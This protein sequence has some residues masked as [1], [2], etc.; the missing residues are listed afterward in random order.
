MD[1]RLLTFYEQELRFIR[2]MGAEFA[3][4]YPKIAGRLGMEGL[5]CADPYVERLLEGF[6]FLT[7][8]VQQKMDARF[9]EFTQQLLDLVYPHL[10]AP[11]PSMAVVGFQPDLSAGA[12]GSGYRLPPGTVL[13]S[14]LGKGERTACEYRTAHEVTL[15]P[16]RLASARYLANPGVMA[17]RGLPTPDGA[18]AAIQIDLELTSGER[19]GD[20]P[21]E[22]L[23]VYLR[24]GDE[25]PMWL[26]EALHAG[27]MGVTLRDDPEQP[28]RLCPGAALRQPGFER[29]EALLP[30]VR[31]AFDGYRLLQEYFACPQR[32]LFAELTGLGAGIKRLDGARLEVTVLLDRS[33]S[34]LE[35]AVDDKAFLLYATPAINLFHHTADRVHVNQQDTEFHVVPDRNRPMDFEVHTVLG[36]TGHGRSRDSA[37][38]FQPFYRVDRETQDHEPGA[39]YAIHRHPRLLS[40]RQRQRGTRTGYLGSEVYLSL[41]DGAQ[42]PYSG[43]LRQL[44]VRTLCTNRDLPI[45][46]A[47]GKGTTDFTLEAAAPVNSVRVDT[48]PTRPRAAFRSGETTWRLI[49][50]LSL[51]YLSLADTDRDRGAEAL[52]QLVELYV[53]TNDPLAR[54]VE[55]VVSVSSKAAVRR[56][57]T[58]GPICFGNGLEVRVRLDEDCFRGVGAFLLGAILDRF[59]GK[60]VSVNSFTQTV[61]ESS[62]RGEIMRWPARA[63]LREV[64]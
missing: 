21:L 7:A 58:R 51:N 53:D 35:Q 30:S 44:E 15:W 11:L 2:E 48:G 8:R 13:R 25:L 36:V 40:A 62:Q 46:M 63:G 54:H 60:Y 24:G 3:R 50:Q 38:V 5:D 34:R 47:V 45:Q 42:A 28:A 26:Y 20:L 56:M 29:D 9:P 57:P 17:A 43:D 32:F 41:V 22:R 37:R 23:P 61:V 52:R 31:R 6:A 27:F 10:T 14:L 33:D 49:S 55:G 18:R 4:E 64:L 59:F 16:L 39:Y 1:A 19:L 12:L